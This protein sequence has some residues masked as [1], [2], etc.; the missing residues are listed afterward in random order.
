M[1]IA[2]ALIPTNADTSYDTLKS[3]LNG[4]QCPIRTYL[5]ESKL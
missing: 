5:E 4:L 3:D 2:W 1:I